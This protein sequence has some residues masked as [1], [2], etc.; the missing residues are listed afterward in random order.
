MNITIKHRSHKFNYVQEGDLF[1]YGDKLFLKRVH[2]REGNTYNACQVGV[3]NGGGMI[4]DHETVFPV[5][6]IVVS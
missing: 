1:I 2:S 6:D 4:A 3:K 5:N